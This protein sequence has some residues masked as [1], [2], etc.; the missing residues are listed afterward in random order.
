M[1]HSDL[2]GLCE[3]TPGSMRSG[4]FTIVFDYNI[5]ELDLKEPGDVQVYAVKAR[6]QARVLTCAMCSRE[7]AITNV[8]RV[9][10]HE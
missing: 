6:S 2:S 3:L 8:R 1:H 7:V 9:C 5:M 4:L 10:M